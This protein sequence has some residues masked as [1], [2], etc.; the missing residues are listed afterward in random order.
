LLAVLISGLIS[1]VNISAESEEVTEVK[2]TLEEY[3]KTLTPEKVLQRANQD[4]EELY[5][6]KDFYPKKAHGR[7]LNTSLLQ[8]QIDKAIRKPKE[9]K[10]F[11]ILYGTSHGTTIT[12][13]GKFMQHL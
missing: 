1:Q 11:D 2:V 9:F 5:G 7:Q 13:K 4:M 8:Q 3:L 6:L 10:G 12:H